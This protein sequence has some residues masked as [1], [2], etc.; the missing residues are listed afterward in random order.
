MLFPA[1]ATAVC[2]SPELNIYN[3]SDRRQPQNTIWTETFPDRP[4]IDIVKI[5]ITPKNTIRYLSEAE[6]R[7]FA[8]VLLRS[9]DILDEGEVI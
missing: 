5:Q 7:V 6:Q 2:F 3:L 9:V 8:Q 1:C 4:A